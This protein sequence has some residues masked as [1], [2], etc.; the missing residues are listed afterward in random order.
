MSSSSDVANPGTGKGSISTLPPAEYWVHLARALPR[1]QVEALRQL[2]DERLNEFIPSNLP[3]PESTAIKVLERVAAD[4]WLECKQRQRCSN[5]EHD[6]TEEEAAQ[7]VCPHCNEAFSDHG[8]VMVETYYV[9]NLRQTRDVGWVVAIHGMNT[10]GAWQEAFTWHLATTWGQSVP[11]AV[12]KYGIVI[13][14]VIMAWRRRTLRENLRKKL[15][16]LRDEARAQ[17]FLGKPDVIAHSFGTWMFGHLLQKELKRREADRLTF[18]RLI[19]TG[20]VLRPDFDWKTIKDAG[21][22]DNVLNHYGTKDRVAPLAHATI[23]DSGPSG[24]RGFDDSEVINVRAEGFGHSDLFSITKFVVAGQC[25]GKRT[26]AAGEMNHLEYAYKRYWK[27]FLTLPSEELAGLPDRANPTKRWQ[28]FPWPLRG[29]IFPFLALP[30]ILSVIILLVA[31]LGGAVEKIREIPR[32][33]VNLGAAGLAS[34]F[35]CIVLVWFW[36]RLWGYVRRI[37]HSA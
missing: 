21:L 24:R 22:V 2:S 20:C 28:Q 16:A 6:L 9:R 13:A 32:I 8:G 4:G 23:Y 19:L 31:S 10:S 17:G 27:P 7:T 34:L 3:R 14:G 37:P 26:S 36:R 30:V 18:G 12:Y 5:C 11:V 1:D 33:S 15:A 29:T 25:F 35:T